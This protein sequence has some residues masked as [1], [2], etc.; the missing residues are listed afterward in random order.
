MNSNLKFASNSTCSYT[1]DC[2]FVFHVVGLFVC[3][4]RM[5]VFSPASS[6]RVK[7]CPITLSRPPRQSA[8]DS[9]IFKKKEKKNDQLQ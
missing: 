9:G 6:L 7:F 2:P 4:L 5:L 8:N 1:Y 3:T